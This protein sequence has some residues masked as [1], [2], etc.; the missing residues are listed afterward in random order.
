[1]VGQ[2]VAVVLV[3]PDCHGGWLGNPGW[4][5]AGT[6]YGWPAMDGRGRGL[7]QRLVEQSAE[8]SQVLAARLSPLHKT[9]SS[10]M[11]LALWVLSQNHFPNQM[12]DIFLLIL[13]PPS[14]SPQN[15]KSKEL[16]ESG[17]D[18]EN[19]FVIIQR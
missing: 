17:Y 9:R 16:P 2:M 3:Q 4:L 19:I 8:A 1:M 5:M 11:T 13:E 18:S 12:R 7:P 6:A 10:D 14:P 15:S